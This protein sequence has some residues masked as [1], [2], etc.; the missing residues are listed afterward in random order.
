[1]T[2]LGWHQNIFSYIFNW[3]GVCVT[4]CVCDTVCVC[5]TVCVCFCV[6]VCNLFIQSVKE[7]EGGNKR[8]ERRNRMNR[9][10]WKRRLEV[11]EKGEHDMDI[12]EDSEEKGSRADSQRCGCRKLN[13]L[14]ELCPALSLALCQSDI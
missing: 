9:T 5:E 6:R 4:L 14:S 12:R 11:D 1:M 2:P 3:D 7:H 10:K 13:A 8:E